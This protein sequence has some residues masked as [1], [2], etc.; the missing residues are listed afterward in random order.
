MGSC[1]LVP[2]VIDR[3]AHANECAAAT[4]GKQQCYFFVLFTL[5]TLCTFL[6]AMICC[7]QLRGCLVGLSPW[8]ST[9]ISVKPNQTANPN[10]AFPK[11]TTLICT[12]SSKQVRRCFCGFPQIP[13]IPRPRYPYHLLKITT[14][15]PSD[16]FPW[17]FR[18]T[19]T[20]PHPGLTSPPV[21]TMEQ[22]SAAALEP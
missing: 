17:S 3:N 11:H 20:I 1:L 7:L 8:L 2:S 18:K 10:P 4:R 22:P 5:L 13:L 9:L 16:I 14:R 21:R 19:P 15:M 12:A 6:I